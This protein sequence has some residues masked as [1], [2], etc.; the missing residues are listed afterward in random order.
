MHLS[1]DAGGA[2]TT[3]GATG[4]DARSPEPAEPMDHGG[5]V[6]GRSGGQP[7]GSYTGP[8]KVNCGDFGILWVLCNDVPSSKLLA[9]IQKTAFGQSLYN[10]ST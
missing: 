8:N 4:S 6:D 10:T 5:L 2:G 9:Q 7:S 3:A 1:G